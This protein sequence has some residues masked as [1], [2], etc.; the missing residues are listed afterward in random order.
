MIIVFLIGLKRLEQ[1]DFLFFCLYSR[2]VY[3]V[4]ILYING[5]GLYEKIVIIL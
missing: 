3:V 4:E 1:A 2:L 5:M